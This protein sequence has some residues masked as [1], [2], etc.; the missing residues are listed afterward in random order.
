MRGG[1]GDAC[2]P[3]ARRAPSSTT[4][5]G[6]AR[7]WRGRRGG[8]RRPAWRSAAAPTTATPTTSRSSA[9]TARLQRAPDADADRVAGRRRCRSARGR[10]SC[11]WTAARR[12]RRAAAADE[13][14]LARGRRPQAV[15]ARADAR[16]PRGARRRARPRRRRAR[17]LQPAPP[18]PDGLRARPRASRCATRSS[19]RASAGASTPTARA[20]S[21]RSSCGAAP[22]SSTCGSSATAAAACR[23]ARPSLREGSRE[24]HEALA[25][26]P[27]TWSTNDHFPDVVRAPRRP[28]VPADLARRRRSSGSASTCRTRAGRSA[29]SSA[30]GTSRSRNWQYVLSPNRFATPIL[31]GA[32]A[33]EGEM[34]ETGYPRDGRARGRRTATRAAR[35]A[36]PARHP[37]GHARRCSTRPTYRDHVDDRRGRYRLDWR[38][39]SIACARAVGPTP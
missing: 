8:R 13:L 5:A 17:P 31:R 9:R 1:H 2:W 20:R 34:L 23:T 12:G 16:R 35:A 6:T 4:C 25:P 22:R 33:I 27:A 3:S 36:R 24:H 28:G 38:S 30:A 29:A 19:T 18:A 32:Y 7:S 15:R 14:P 21:T 39:T 11:A 37:G 10:G 26:A